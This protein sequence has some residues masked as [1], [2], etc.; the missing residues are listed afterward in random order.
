MYIIYLEVTDTD[1]VDEAIRQDAGRKNYNVATD[2]GFEARFCKESSSV[3]AETETYDHPGQVKITVDLKELG[4]ELK[5]APE[6]TERTYYLAH[7]HDG[8]NVEYLPVS[9][10]KD[11][12]EATFVTDRLSPFAFVYRDRENSRPQPEKENGTEKRYAIPMTG[13]E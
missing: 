6:G 1:T 5:D 12:S 13:I 9:I 2:S 11:R 7:S 8:K 3:Y 10:S 4:I